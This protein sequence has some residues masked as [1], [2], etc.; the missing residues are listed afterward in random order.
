MDTEFKSIEEYGAKTGYSIHV[1]DTNPS[2][3]ISNLDDVSQVQKYE[4]SDEEY[5][6]R[7]NTFRKFKQQMIEKNANFMNP[8]ANIVTDY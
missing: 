6:K 8:Q 7:E 3:L 4:I 2:E 1:V 5:D